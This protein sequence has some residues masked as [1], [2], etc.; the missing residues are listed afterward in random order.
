MNVGGC[1]LG[2]PPTEEVAVAARAV[3]PTAALSLSSSSSSPPPPASFRK[4]PETG[5][6]PLKLPL[7]PLSPLPLPPLAPPSRSLPSPP[8]KDTAAALVA[9]RAVNL[10]FARARGLLLPLFAVSLAAAP[11]PAPA[12]AAAAAATLSRLFA[13]F[14]SGFLTMS[15]PALVQVPLYVKMPGCSRL[16]NRWGRAG[17][18]R[19][20]FD[21]RLGGNAHQ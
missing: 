13:A 1:F 8:R 17:G 20:G 9:A 18:G 14:S 12:A 11:A 6:L 3:V 10:D 16:A 15:S 7:P 2:T 5:A 21:I 4:V 19:Q